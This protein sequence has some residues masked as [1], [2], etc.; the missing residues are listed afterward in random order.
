LL[1]A[2]QSEAQMVAHRYATL[3]E[4]YTHLKSKYDKLVRPAR[5]ARGRYRVEVRYWKRDG[6]YQIAWREGTAGQFQ[7]VSRDA[8][9][10]ILTRLDQQHTEG[11]YIRVVLPED[12]ELSH[13]EA[14]KFTLSL[15][16]QYDY[17]FKSSGHL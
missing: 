16:Q 6:E 12:S 9:D 1:L 10:K 17:Y 5:S 7:V 4:D 8:L 2:Q 3:E 15:H 11:L 13:T 14:W